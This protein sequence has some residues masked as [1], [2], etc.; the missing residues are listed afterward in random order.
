MLRFY[1][2]LSAWHCIKTACTVSILMV[3]IKETGDFE[4]KLTWKLTPRAGGPEKVTWQ[5]MLQNLRIFSTERHRKVCF[6]RFI[7][8]ESVC[9]IMLL[10]FNYYHQTCIFFWVEHYHSSLALKPYSMNRVPEWI[11]SKQHGVKVF[12]KT[13][14]FIHCP[15]HKSSPVWSAKKGLMDIA[16]D[17]VGSTDWFSTQITHSKKISM[18]W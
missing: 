2:S 12:S 9:S 15:T 16:V 14:H 4:C 10:C 17:D 6:E 8:S 1:K 11:I 13:W 18:T 7:S 5:V 3:F